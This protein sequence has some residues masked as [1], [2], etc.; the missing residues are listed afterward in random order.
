MSKFNHVVAN[1]VDLGWPR[2]CADDKKCIL[3]LVLPPICLLWQTVH[4]SQRLDRTENQ[5]YPKSRKLKGNSIY[6]FIL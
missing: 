4:P 2:C 6:K 5:N 3:A 1:L